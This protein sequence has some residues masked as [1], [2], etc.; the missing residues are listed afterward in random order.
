MIYNTTFILFLVWA[1]VHWSVV[2]HQAQ[3]R[4]HRR[5]APALHTG[6]VPVRPGGLQDL[7]RGPR[8]A[9]GQ[10]HRGKGWTNNE[11]SCKIILTCSLFTIDSILYSK[12]R[13]YPSKFVRSNFNPHRYY[14]LSIINFSDCCRLFEI[15]IKL[16]FRSFKFS[17]FDSYGRHVKLSTI[18]VR[19]KYSGLYSILFLVPC[20]LYQISCNES[21][22]F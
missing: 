16:C 11:P 22:S 1:A 4:D 12:A 2:H 5:G 3:D 8:Q 6:P 9:A 7:P 20:F 21:F 19:V 17:Q 14:G 15:I 18:K 13:T 10:G